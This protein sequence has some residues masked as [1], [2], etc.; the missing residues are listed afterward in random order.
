M[1]HRSVMIMA[2]GTGGHIYP[3]LAVADYLKERGTDILWLGTKKGMESKIVPEHGYPLFYLEISGVRG[4]GLIKKLIAPFII[5][6]AVFQSLSIM[7]KQKPAAVLG[8][9]GFASGPGGIAAYIL[10]I[11]LCIH[12]QNSVAGLTNKLLKPFA[13]LV[14]Q[15]FPNS[16]DASKKV[17]TTGNPVRKEIIEI[18]TKELE[19]N[20][21]AINILIIGGSLGAKKLNNIVPKTLIKLDK[22]MDF[23]VR[24]QCGEKHQDETVKLYKELK[25]EASVEPF[26]KDM[27]LAYQW[28]DLIICRAG[29]MTIAEISIVGIP[30]VLIPYPYAVDDHQSANA[31]YLSEQNLAILIQESEMTETSLLQ[32]IEELSKSSEYLNELTVKIRKM[33]KPKATQMVAEKCLEVMDV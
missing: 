10:G 6:K 22:K 11:P 7:K 12:E 25:L 14:M 33:G 1:L 24:H 19:K 27:A 26:I 5:F 18:E 4:K 16:F 30:A 20:K 13:H 21:A 17:I 31:R 3:A 32:A 9:G 2:G 15:A 8:M 23:N 29:A 28:A